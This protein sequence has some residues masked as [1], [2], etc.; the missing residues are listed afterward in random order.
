MEA[1]LNRPRP[2][3]WEQFWRSPWVFIARN[4]YSLRQ[5][6]PFRPIS[7][8]ISVVCVSDTHNSQPVLPDGDIL[9]H[10][11]DMTQ[12]GSFKEL[13]VTLDWLNAQ[14]HPHKIV[15]AGNHDKLLDPGKDGQDGME[16]LERK[17]S[18]MN[19]RPSPVP[20]AEFFTST[21]APFH[22]NMGTGLSRIHA[23]TISGPARYQTIRIF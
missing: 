13:Q 23:K 1:L 18:A 20:T 16:A 10:A 19:P 21:A 11:G 6:I 5:V 14:P 8:P 17:I 4:L 9:I 15:I 22:G 2:S 7:N 12:S 3:I